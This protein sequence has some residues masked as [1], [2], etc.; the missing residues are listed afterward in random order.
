SMQ[1]FLTRGL[2]AALDLD[3]SQQFYAGTGAGEALGVLNADCLV[4]VPKET[5]Q[6]ATTLLYENTL[7]MLARFYGS[8]GNWYGSRTII[9]QLGIM[10]VA[11][12]TGGSTVFMSNQGGVGSFP[13]QLHGSGLEY[14]DVAP[15]LG[16]VGDLMLA[17][18]SQYLVGQRAGRGGLEM[19]ESMHLKF[20]FDQNT[21]KARYY[22]DGQ[23]WWP[24]AFRPLNGASRSPFVV[25]ATRA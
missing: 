2:D 24:Q 9:P 17:D 18:W 21:F 5:E 8:R 10:S 11:V 14:L 7:N 12:G 19:S 13:A 4:S 23:P 15:T 20:D 3:M 22:I 1:P 25:V 6:V 16:T